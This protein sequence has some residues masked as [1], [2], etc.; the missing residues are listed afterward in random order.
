MDQHYRQG[1]NR[2][3]ELY[4]H[5]TSELAI[6]D[7]STSY[8]RIRY[9]PNTI[10]RILSHVPDVRIIYIV[11]HPLERMVSAYVYRLGTPGPGQVF[12]SI[13]HAVR[14]QPMI[15]DS[16]RYWEVFDC[17]RKHF[18]ES[19][20]KIIWFEEFT[21]NTGNTFK[22][23]CRFLE[24]DDTIEIP[25]DHKHQNRREDALQR[26][27]NLGRAD[28]PI[29]TQWDPETRKWVIDQLHDDN[30]RFLAHFGK[31]ANYWGDLF[32]S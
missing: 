20:I 6:G 29:E 14:Q 9:H 12:A 23:V 3:Q 26:M 15:I 2:Y 16:S 27:R 19:R 25:I 8:S 31:P 5:C 18:D 24:I 32:T 4:D 1:W 22:E 21:K 7:A 30:C 11:R 10:R 28:V 13:N 17:Y